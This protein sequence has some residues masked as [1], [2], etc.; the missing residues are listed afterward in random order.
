MNKFGVC[1]ERYLVKNKGIWR[2]C[3]A[4][5][6]GYTH[7]GGFIRFLHIRSFLKKLYFSRVLDAGCGTGP[8]SFY[9]A[10]RYKDVKIDSVDIE[11]DNIQICQDI[12]NTST[13]T[14]VRFFYK[15]IREFNVYNSY[16]F[17]LCVDVLEHIPIHD[18]TVVIKNLFYGMKFG[19]HLL[20]HVPIRGNKKIFNE[21][22]FERATKDLKETHKN[23]I[24]DTS[25]VIHLLTDEGF[26]INEVKNTFGLLGQFLWEIDKIS[27]EHIKLLYAIF[28]PFLKILCFLEARLFY[29]RGNGLL[30]LASKERM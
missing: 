6:C 25:G 14:N 22:F 20:L 19:G 26:I 17:I 7:I 5:L 15:D 9:L 13:L 27:Y 1:E 10:E 3:Y 21:K 24:F 23:D 18:R 29:H 16:D 12:L 4:R 8:Y 2:K 11:Q 28:L 30:V